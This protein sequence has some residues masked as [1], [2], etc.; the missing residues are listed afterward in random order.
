MRMAEIR[1]HIDAEVVLAYGLGL[2]DLRLIFED[3]PILDRG[4][5]PLPGEFRS[6]V[7][8]DQ[9]MAALARRTGQKN[10]LWHR[11][12]RAAQALGATAY[13]P[14]EV[15]LGGENTKGSNLTDFE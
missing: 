2:E 5:V 6:T 1:A 10:T 3:F 15:T 9:A 4:Q 14:S 8:R 13:V 11:R 12:S 7:T